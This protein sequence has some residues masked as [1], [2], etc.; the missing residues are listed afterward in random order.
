MISFDTLCIVEAQGMDVGSVIWRSAMAE[1]VT[2][3][4]AAAEAHVLH[5]VFRVHVISLA[6][7]HCACL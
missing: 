5:A 7:R 3:R 6:V 4:G 1:Q 2:Q